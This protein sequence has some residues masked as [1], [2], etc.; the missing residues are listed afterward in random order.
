MLYRNYFVNILQF[1]NFSDLAMTDESAALINVFFGK[2][3]CE[4]NS[5]GKPERM[6]QNVAVLGAGL[7]G[8]GIATVRFQKYVKGFTLSHPFQLFI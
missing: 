4:K 3:Q 7:M 8:A 2:Q 1:Q 5:F 6:P